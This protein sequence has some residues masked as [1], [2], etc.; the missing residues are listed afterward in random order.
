MT[1]VQSHGAMVQKPVFD[2]IP[3]KS[4]MSDVITRFFVRDVETDQVDPKTGLRVFRP[5]EYVELIIPGDK[6]SIV[7]RR[8][9]DEL[10]QKYSAAYRHFKERG[11]ALDL[12]GDGLPLKAWPGIKSDVAR[13]LEQINIF[14]VQQLASIADQK[15]SQPGFMGLRELRDKARVFLEE[16]GKTAPLANMQKQIDDMKQQM[17]LISQQRDEMIQ[18]NNELQAQVSGGVPQT[19]TAPELTTP[20]GRN[21]EK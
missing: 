15:L 11:E 2:S 3:R 19:E 18:K 17:A 14:S 9:N 21:K 1:L 4:D 12:A 6:N 20:R 13:G 8:V 7:E 16:A 10:R 5:V